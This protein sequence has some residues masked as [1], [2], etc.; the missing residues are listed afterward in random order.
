MKISNRQFVNEWVAAV[1]K[2]A[3][4][5]GAA[6]KLGMS[7]KAVSMRANGLRKRCVELPRMRVV[8]DDYSVEEL[9]RI[10]ENKL[11]VQA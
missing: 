1:N 7:T 3:G 2:G 11:E 5:K 6:E 4:V 10:I 8:S 9:N